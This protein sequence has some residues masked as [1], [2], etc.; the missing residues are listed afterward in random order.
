MCQIDPFLVVLIEDL[1]G[2]LKNSYC[3]E[4]SSLEENTIEN[5]TA[6]F[7]WQ[8]T[9]KE[10]THISNTSFSYMPNIYARNHF[11]K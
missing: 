6:Q 9:I 1:N 11:D 5:V 7:G 2:N 10:P 8:Q 4:K 3:Y